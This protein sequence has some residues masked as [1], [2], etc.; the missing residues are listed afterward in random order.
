LDGDEKVVV[1]WVRGIDWRWV[2]SH[3]FYRR[4]EAILLCFGWEEERSERKL[5]FFSEWELVCSALVGE[6][7]SVVPLRLRRNYSGC[8]EYLQWSFGLSA[9]SQQYFSLRTNQP[10]ETSQQYF[11]LRTNQH[12]PSATSHPNRLMVDATVQYCYF[13]LGGSTRYLLRLGKNYGIYTQIITRCSSKRH[14]RK[15]IIDNITH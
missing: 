12:Q 15:K 14:S 13:I 8:L 10:P 9:T 2:V 1:P 3:E 7:I 4:T 5:V 6:Q 11:S